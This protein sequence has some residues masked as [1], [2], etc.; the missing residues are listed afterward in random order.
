MAQEIRT[1][2]YLLHPPL[3]DQLGLVS[4]VREYA[5]GFGQRSGIKLSLELPTDFGRLPQNVEMALFRIVQES[6]A[7]VQRHSGANLAQITMQLQDDQLILEISDEG[8]GMV[9]SA[10]D[11]RN[12]KA[13]L[14]GVGILGMQ[15][16][17]GQLGG[18]LDIN[19]SSSGTAVRA[20]IPWTAEV[21]DAGSY[22][23]RG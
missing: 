23:R 21:F 16:R 13:V 2:S 9:Q 18:K 1:M 7:N 6:L 8:H 3:L 22:P 5:Q 20:T 4:A 12:G 17:M 10:A 15:E 11:M 19:S 14:L